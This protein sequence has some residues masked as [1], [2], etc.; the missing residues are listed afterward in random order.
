MDNISNNL[1][2][3]QV[4]NKKLLFILD[5]NWSNLPT[6]NNVTKSYGGHGDEAEVESIKE[7]QVFNYRKGRGSDTQEENEKQ[8]ATGSSF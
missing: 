2:F 4:W 1:T 7:C 8:E 3:W 6:R 5:K